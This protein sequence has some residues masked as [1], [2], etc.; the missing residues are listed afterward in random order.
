MNEELSQVLQIGR[1]IPSKKL[2]SQ[3]HDLLEHLWEGDKKVEISAILTGAHN[4]S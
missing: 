4:D 2:E 3:H 1:P